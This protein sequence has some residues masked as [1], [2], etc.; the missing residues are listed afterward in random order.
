[1]NISIPMQISEFIQVVPLN[2]LISK[3]QIKVCWVG[4]E[5]NRNG[6]VITKE[7][8]KKMAPSLPGCPIVGYYNYS[9]EDFDEHNKTIKISN[10]KVKIVEDTKPY[11]FVDM[12]S[13][14][15][16]QFFKD[17]DGV[18]REYLMVEGYIWS[19]VYEE[20]QRIVKKGNN[21]SMELNEKTLEGHWAKSDNLNKQ[22]FIINDGL[23]EKLCVLGENVEPCFEG[24]Q[25]KTQFSLTEE[26]T[27][28]LF[29]MAN[30]LK[31]ILSEGGQQMFTTYTVEIGDNL[32]N[33][34]YSHLDS[35][36]ADDAG[37]SLYRIVGVY[38]DDAQKFAIVS[39]KNSDTTYRMNFECG[40]TESFS[41]SDLI[42]VESIEL[43][44]N[45]TF[46]L[47]DV[48][49]F[50]NSR[51]KKKTD[52]EEENTEEQSG[53]D[54][55]DEDENNDD[56]DEKK[57]KN[58]YSLEDIPEYQALL[59]NYSNLESSYNDLNAKYETLESQLRDLTQFK[60]NIDLQQ[61]QE[62]INK[63]YMLSDEDKADVITN[64]NTYS[65]EDIESK[66]SVICFRNKV[67]FD[68]DNS[69]EESEEI[70][71]VFKLTDTDDASVPAWIKA[72]EKRKNQ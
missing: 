49:S 20:S 42:E 27:Q 60:A 26:F 21:Q 11:G 5:P 33:A 51:Y 29:A 13:Q 18:V 41:F 8:A 59:S 23:F 6:T 44:E 68:L 32:W 9:T 71:T 57:K 56:E 3:C 46:S 1:M 48:E 52:E 72:I 50:E 14:I 69:E 37:V 45:S 65:L 43:P 4:E 70:P 55:S 24:A 30:E 19:G 63:F 22:F 58:T 2:P 64:I 28:S 53:S 61:K 10:G 25:I 47:E 35:N 38:E 62:M 39:E 7:T 54:S 34:I 40:E 66:L 15:W 31:Q 12:H 67:S 16:F 36:H 17:F